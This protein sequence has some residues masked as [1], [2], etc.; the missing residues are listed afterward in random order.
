[1]FE[2]NNI[3]FHLSSNGI[4]MP[5]VINPKKTA[6]LVLD[7]Q[8]AV[9]NRPM[10]P[11]D[12]KDVVRNAANLADAFRRA[13]S[14]VVMVN[15]SYDQPFKPIADVE[16]KDLNSQE[17]WD[18]LVD[19]L[20]V[21]ESDIKITKSGWSAFAGTGLDRIL[22]SRDIDT[23][24]LCGI[25]TNIGVET[26][27]RDAYDLRYNQIFVVDA[28]AA[29]SVEEHEHTIKYIFGRTGLVRNTEDIIFALK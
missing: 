7:L 26:T 18:K 2:N 13:G 17:G 22:K 4:S 23:L 19:G 14:V 20:N 28:M 6:L 8:N 27:A 3:G 5:L 16:T 12:P 10:V 9:V 11:N 1:M 15:L 29:K 24:V 25:S 21:K